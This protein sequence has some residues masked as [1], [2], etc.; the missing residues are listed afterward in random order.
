MRMDCLSEADG[1]ALAILCEQWSRYVEATKKLRES[2]AVYAVRDE[3][4]KLRMLKRNPYSS[5]QLE[6]AQVVRRALGE[7][8]L[9]P[10][11]RSRVTLELPGIGGGSGPASSL[12][13]RTQA[14]RG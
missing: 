13:S 14:M 5:I 2:G 8:G 9:T 1:H 10:A 6:L 3:K 12:F 4:G 11:A 7:F